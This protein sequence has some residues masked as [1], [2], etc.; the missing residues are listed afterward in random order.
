MIM[1][2]SQSTL[3]YENNENNSSENIHTT[4]YQV[5]RS[6]VTIDDR[7]L[8]S[9]QRLG[10]KKAG[11]I[12]N[13]N[14]VNTRNDYKR[15]QCNLPLKAKYM[16]SFNTSVQKIVK[17]K[18]N[19]NLLPTD[20]VIIY[21][22]SGCQPQAAHCDYIPDQALKTVDDAQM[23]LAIL[24]ALMPDTHLNVWPNSIR[25][26][27]AKPEQLKSINPIP[28]ETIDLN[29]G[30]MLVFRGDFVHAGSG[31]QADNYRIHYYLDSPKVP[32][33]ANRTWLIPK[34]QNDPLRK[35]IQPSIQNGQSFF[36]KQASR[37]RKNQ[38]KA[39]SYKIMK[40]G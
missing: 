18:I 26:A 37:K 10:E 34:N 22:K 4:G 30:D 16:R 7:I 8:K 2:R 31:Y 27:T 28:C 21:S 13:H 5:I 9:A 36:S 6:A 17:N 3:T 33:T 35:I 25:L 40:P 24:I 32:R 19:T 15:L 23:P 29:S 20:P 12:F 11:A 38:C 1:T 39:A 14:E